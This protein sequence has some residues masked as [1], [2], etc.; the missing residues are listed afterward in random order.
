MTAAIKL[1]SI[2]ERTLSMLKRRSDILDAHLKMY[3]KVPAGK[4]DLLACFLTSDDSQGALKAAWESY[5]LEE[6][7]RVTSLGEHCNLTELHARL[8]N[9]VMCLAASPCT[10]GVGVWQGI[11]DDSRRQAAVEVLNW[12]SALLPMPL[13]SPYHAIPETRTAAGNCQPQN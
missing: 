9:E 12:L 1:Q 11:R 13:E 7:L 5:Y 2:K 6:V 4:G 8:R 3:Q 10:H